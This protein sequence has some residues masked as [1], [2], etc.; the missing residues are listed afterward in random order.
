MTRFHSAM[1]ILNP[2]AHNASQIDVEAAGRQIEKAGVATSVVVPDSIEAS[3]KA[4]QEAVEGGR[5]VVFMAGGDGTLRQA[6]RALGNTDTALAPIPLGTANVLA[7]EL[8]IP[9]D[10]QEAIEAHLQGQTQAMDVG[11]AGDEPFLAMASIGWDAEV[12]A[13]VNL[14][15]KKRAGAAAYVLSGAQRLRNL[16]APKLLEG[17]L[18]HVEA[19]GDSSILVISNTR[20][21]GGVVEFTPNALADDG[22]FDLCAVKPRNLL[23]GLQLIV[24][25]MRRSLSEDDL[26]SYG[27][28]SHAVV[29]TPDVTVQV[30]GDVIGE[31]PM[32]FT[33]AT[34]ALKISVPAGA[35]PPIFGDSEKPAS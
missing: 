10:W 31:T 24:R 16:L 1:L 26:T 27:Q 18:D 6:A 8:G 28:A 3:T 20:N 7:K 9:R 21:Y 34:R 4:L 5:D 13:N 30:D 15:V 17:T 32:T 14:A 2:H 12:A 11:W 19:V 25:L 33:L 29:E 23:H 22:V 35:L